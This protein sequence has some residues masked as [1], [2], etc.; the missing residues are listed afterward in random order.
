MNSQRL[1]VKILFGIVL[2][3][4]VVSFLNI[5]ISLF[6]PEPKYE[7]YCTPQIY[8]PESEPERMQKDFECSKS[9]ERVMNLKLQ[10]L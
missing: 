3:I 2:G 5:G 8:K 1:F 10:S 4:L 7:D 6:Y 9:Y